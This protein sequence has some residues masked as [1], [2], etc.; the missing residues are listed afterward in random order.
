MS[1]YSQAKVDA[2]K[3]F[4]VADDDWSEELLTVKHIT[5]AR[6]LPDGRGV[7]GSRLRQLYEAR[8][9]A[10]ARWADCLIEVA[11]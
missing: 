9:L 5:N 8:A 3:A 11:A 1:H 10:Y 4:A 7:E 2:Y 6:Y